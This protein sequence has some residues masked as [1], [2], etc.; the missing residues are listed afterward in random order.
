MTWLPSA[1]SKRAVML[2]RTTLPGLTRPPRRMRVP[3]PTCF[4][5]TSV[6]VLKNTMES[7]SALSTSATAT[8]RTVRLAPMR[9]RR[10]CLRVMPG[11]RSSFEPEAFD[12]L[13]EA[14]D[15]LAVGAERAARV[16][17]GGAGLILVAEHRVGT[18]QPQPTFD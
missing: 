9:T 17:R 5:T 7:R 3:A 18:H 14:A 8:A 1:I 15:L 4:S 10:R 2:S 11:L 12:E 6:G 16:R 13:V